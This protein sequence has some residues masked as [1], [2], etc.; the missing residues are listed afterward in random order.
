MLDIVLPDKLSYCILI[1]KRCHISTNF[2]IQYFRNAFYRN[3]ILSCNR[4]RKCVSCN[5]ESDLF[6]DT[7]EV[8]ISFK[9]RTVAIRGN[10]KIDR[11]SPFLIVFWLLHVE[12]QAEITH[13][14]YGN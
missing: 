9:F 1:F 3:S 14:S 11:S 10:V 7:T 4:C 5:V 6:L 8:Y 13:Q 2:N 12:E